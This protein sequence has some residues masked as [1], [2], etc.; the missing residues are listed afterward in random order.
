[1]YRCFD[2]SDDSFLQKDE[3]YQRIVEQLDSFILNLELEDRQLALKMI[4]NCYHE[5][6]NS[7]KTKSQSDTELLAS[8][9]M[10]LLIEQSNKIERLS[11]LGKTRDN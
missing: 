6:H 9:T 4:S 3:T 7:I 10:T 2:H 5:F 1:M 11:L 8:T